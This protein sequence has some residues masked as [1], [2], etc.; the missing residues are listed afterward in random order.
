MTIRRTLMKLAGNDWLNFVLTNRIPRR[1][2]GR[3]VGW[4]SHSENRLVC[5]VSLWVWRCFTDL[6]L[7]DAETTRFCSMHACFT[8]NLKPGARVIDPDPGVQV[9]PCDGI[10]GAFG[11]IENGRMMQVKG[12]DYTLAELLDDAG[13]A[14]ELEGSTFVTL[15]LTSAMYHRFHAP[16]DCRVE[17][18]RHVFGDCWNVNPPTLR[19]VAR[20]FCRNERVVVRASCAGGQ[21]L[22]LVAVAAILVS[23]IRLEFLQLNAQ[24]GH[25]IHQTYPCHADV[26]KGDKMGWFEHGSTIVMIVPDGWSMVETLREGARIRMGQ[27]LF[28]LTALSSG[29]HNPQGLSE[30]KP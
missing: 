25:P 21:T 17:R 24:G 22:T 12:M 1:L 18:V 9:S 7:S 6:D 16:Y 11:R 4:I 29:G 5:A 27:P 8:R 2:A 14:A 15:R 10:V 3:C 26:A 20:L 19:R 13:D 28:R 30:L 23:G